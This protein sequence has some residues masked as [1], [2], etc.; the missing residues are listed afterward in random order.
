[1]PEH[2]FC[3]EI[4]EYK[5]E[6]LGVRGINDGLDTVLLD[7]TNEWC[8]HVQQLSSTQQLPLRR[9]TFYFQSS[10]V[11]RIFTNFSRPITKIL[12]ISE[13]YRSV[14]VYWSG[15][16]RGSLALKLLASHFALATY[17]WDTSSQCSRVVSTFISCR[18]AEKREKNSGGQRLWSLSELR[19]YFFKKM[20]HFIMLMIRALKLF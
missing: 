14:R 15:W 5:E 13:C 18:W 12:T 2:C 3:K 20:L 4:S 8:S 6:I 1:M 9:Q 16:R 7:I 19:P 11:R 17:N 10:H